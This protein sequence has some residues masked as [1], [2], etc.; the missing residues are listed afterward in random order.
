MR[1][2]PFRLA[3]ALAMILAACGGA[4]PS[5]VPSAIPSSAPTVAPTVTPDPTP[6]PTL[7][8]AG[9]VGGELAEAVVAA[10]NADP[11]IVR[12][13]QIG[14]A[15]TDLAPGTEV[16]AE[17]SYDLSGDDLHIRMR[18]GSPGQS[19][20]TEIIVVGDTTWV[21]TDGAAWETAPTVEVAATLD[22]M[23]AAIRLVGDPDQLR[24]VGS[25]V[26]DGRELQHL[27]AAG[28]IPYAPASGGTGQYDVFDIYVEPDGTPVYVRTAYS[29]VDGNGFEGTGETDFVFSD[30]GG[31]IVIEPPTD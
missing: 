17:G 27:T 5:D 12:V 1:L 15:R 8:P 29:A 10:L 30:F 28:T 20:E 13:E 16:T 14:T 11:L 6:A 31:P 22:A 23:S 26:I 7:T 4:A 2:A 24:H 25:E 19:F 18:F 21:R 9:E 3:L